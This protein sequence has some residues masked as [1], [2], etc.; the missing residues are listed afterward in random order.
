MNLSGDSGT[1]YVLLFHLNMFGGS[2][3][4]GLEN[5]IIGLMTRLLP[6]IG[7][8]RKAVCRATKLIKYCKAAKQIP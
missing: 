4:S 1:D 6:A 7:R 2:T 3:G 8:V 5:G